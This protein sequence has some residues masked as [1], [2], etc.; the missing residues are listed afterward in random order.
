MQDTVA[1]KTFSYL[2]GA[3]VI[4]A[5]DILKKAAV[6]DDDIVVLS[7]TLVEG[8]GNRHS[9]LDIYVI[10]KEK[11]SAEAIGGRNFVGLS[12]DGNVGQIYDYLDD[13]GFGF[14]VEYF[15]F[16]EIEALKAKIDAFH[17]RACSSSKILRPRLELAEDDAIHKFHV[18]TVLQG[19]DAFARLLPPSTFE[20]IAF[21]MYR[22]RTGGYPEVKDMMGAWASGDIDTCIQVTQMYLTEQASGLC[23]LLGS[24][25]TKPKWVFANL[26]RLPAEFSEIGERTRAWLLGDKSTDAKGR[27]AILQACDLIDDIFQAGGSILERPGQHYS[28]ADAIKLTN[29]DY[30][31]ETFHDTQTK[32]EFEHRRCVIGQRSIPMRKFLAAGA[33]TG[34]LEDV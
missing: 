17:A 22:N 20:K 31:R 2:D 16:D 18:G 28:K 7:G 11:P 4:S 9:D 13:V 10:C 29:Q 21:V 24:T 26:K 30:E 33:T 34:V 5:E 23:H 1:D 3:L 15:T 12:Q 14:D 6:K 27:E 8:I 25:N 19:K 32:L